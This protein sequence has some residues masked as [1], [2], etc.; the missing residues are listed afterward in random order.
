MRTI[1]YDVIGVN[2]FL[3]T[4]M[5]ILPKKGDNFIP[6]IL[7]WYH[8]I[9]SSIACSHRSD[10]GERCEVKKAMKSEG[11]LFIFLSAFLLRTT[12]HYLNAWNRLTLLGKAPHKPFES[13][14][15]SSWTNSSEL[16]IQY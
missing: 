4:L 1:A 8:S 16:L 5:R 7:L 9:H 3:P 6:P 15:A 12:P 2:V 14:L 10:N 13:K 11:G